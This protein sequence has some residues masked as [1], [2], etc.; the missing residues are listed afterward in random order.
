MAPIPAGATKGGGPCRRLLGPADPHA[1][2]RGTDQLVVYAA[3]A[4]PAVLV[5][6]SLLLE[7]TMALAFAGVTLKIVRGRRAAHT[8]S[9]A[10][11]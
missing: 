3:L 1:R 6:T 10:S 5:W 9:D 2:V 4:A 11:P 8:G 7:L